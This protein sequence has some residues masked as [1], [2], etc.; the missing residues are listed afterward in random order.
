MRNLIA[1]MKNPSSTPSSPSASLLL[2]CVIPRLCA[3]RESQMSVKLILPAP[4]NPIVIPASTAKI[5]TEFDELLKARTGD[6]VKTAVSSFQNKFNV[7]TEEIVE[8]V[9]RYAGEKTA[10]T[11]N[12][13]ALFWAMVSFA[14]SHRP[15]AYEL[16]TFLKNILSLGLARSKMQD[17][18]VEYYH[19]TPALLA[20]S[21]M[22]KRM[23]CK[24]L[25][26]NGIFYRAYRKKLV[27]FLTDRET[28][29][30]VEFYHHPEDTDESEKVFEDIIIYKYDPDGAGRPTTGTSPAS[31]LLAL[32]GMLPKCRVSMPPDFYEAAMQSPV[33]RKLQ[34]RNSEYFAGITS[35]NTSYSVFRNDTNYKA[36]KKDG[37]IAGVGTVDVTFDEAYGSNSCYIGAEQLESFNRSKEAARQKN[38]RHAMRRL[39]V[40]KSCSVDDAYVHLEYPTDGSEESSETG[41][42]S[43]DEQCVF[44]EDDSF[45]RTDSLVNLVLGIQP[46]RIR[47]SIAQMACSRWDEIFEALPTPSREPKGGMVIERFFY[48][49]PYNFVKECHFRQLEGY[50]VEKFC[51]I[52]DKQHSSPWIFEVLGS[53]RFLSIYVKYGHYGVARKIRDLPLETLVLQYDGDRRVHYRKLKFLKIVL[54]STTL[55]TIVIKATG[56]DIAA[57]AE[58]IRGM[59]R[60]SGNTTVKKVVC[61]KNRRIHTIKI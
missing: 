44:P 59:I 6:A 16:S 27:V 20:N 52:Y 3:M 49:D 14:S 5:F 58:E 19:R 31:L 35:L 21:W 61:Y 8:M 11:I 30:L 22:L 29:D 53:L 45:A 50:A 57:G 26:M 10:E 18:I 24:L 47:M 17:K 54:G 55:K 33:L 23:V 2:L 39:K 32:I 42:E 41:D 36:F 1:A 25:A 13:P 43:E 15:R 37:L 40:K 56:N 38:A 9:A 48:Y 7:N 28:F 4:E 46:R 34:I 51:L 60:S 12:D